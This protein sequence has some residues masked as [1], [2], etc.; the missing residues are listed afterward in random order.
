MVKKMLKFIDD[1][2]LDLTLTHERKRPQALDFSV[3]KTCQWISECSKYCLCQALQCRGRWSFDNQ[4]RLDVDT[5]S[6]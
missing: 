3:S 5:P 6:L 1:E 2:Y 4:D